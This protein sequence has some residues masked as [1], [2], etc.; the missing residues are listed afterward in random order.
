MLTHHFRGK[1]PELISRFRKLNGGNPPH[2]LYLID[3]YFGRTAGAEGALLKIARFLPPDRYRCSLVTFATDLEASNLSR[4]FG[5][6]VHV[7][8]LTCTYNLEA[9]RVALRLRHIIRSE[10][11][12]LVHTFFPIADLWGGIVS[13]L[14]GVPIL[15]SSRR[16]MGIFRT[17]LHSLAYRLLGGLYDKVHA[18]SEE[19]RAFTIREDRLRP[20]RVVTIHNGVDLEEIDAIR[21]RGRTELLPSLAGASHLIGSVGNVR[22][23]KGVD[24]LVRAAAVVCQKF[25][26]AVFL[27]IGNI[28]DPE[29]LK[30]L[31]TQ[32]Q[33]LG[34]S[35][36]IFFLGRRW[37]VISLLKV[38]DAFC[39]LSRSEGQS[40]AIL[41]AMA[42]G[43]PCVVTRV[44]GN[45][46][47]VASGESGFLVP[48]EQPESAGKH[49]LRLLQ[50]PDMAETMG[51]R[52]RQIIESRFTMQG[53]IERLMQVYDE[54]LLNDAY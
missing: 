48:S 21:L 33:N 26:R 27:V 16:D 17:E 32:I 52:G 37:D 9:F 12:K 47:V 40:N 30:E 46:E 20:S 4:Q 2:V 19:V 3:T 42:C 36:N 35:E 22:R 41:E 50:N 49:L 43:L 10:N 29:Y 1:E 18:V 45:A 15:F 7:L 24:I 54:L 5:C 38:C 11:V 25:P 14:C 44:G 8:P 39:L 51:K 28:H 6:P 23:V 53:T 13:K 31:Q 34:L